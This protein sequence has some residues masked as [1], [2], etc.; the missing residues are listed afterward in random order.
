VG[1]RGS[2][3]SVSREDLIVAWAREDLIVAWA[4][5]DLIVAW[6]REDLIVACVRGVRMQRGS[7]AP[8]MPSVEPSQVQ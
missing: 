5:E 6:A 8:T 7:A 1:Q 4:R 2:K 3:G